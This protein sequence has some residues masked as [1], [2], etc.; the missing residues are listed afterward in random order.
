MC[1]HSRSTSHLCCQSWLLTISLQCPLWREVRT[2]VTTTQTLP[3]LRI[4]LQPRK[5]LII[6]LSQAWIWSWLWRAAGMP[7]V[8]APGHHHRGGKGHRDRQNPTKTGKLVE[9]LRHGSVS[10]AAIYGQEVMSLSNAAIYWT[11]HPHL[12]YGCL[13]KT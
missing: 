8:R 10:T 2:T 3:M 6:L 12:G 5:R 4:V 13:M 11:F 7:A 9:A 1:R